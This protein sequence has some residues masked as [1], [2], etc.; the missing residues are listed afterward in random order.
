VDVAGFVDAAVLVA[1]VDYA[2]VGDNIVGE[3][4]EAVLVAEVAA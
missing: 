1:A 4:R 3:L 2:F